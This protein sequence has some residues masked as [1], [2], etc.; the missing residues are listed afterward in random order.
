[1]GEPG[2]LPSMGSHRVGYDW[3]D[4]AVAAARSLSK[5]ETHTMEYYSAIKSIK[6]SAATW[7]Q[8][9]FIIISEVSQRERQ[10]TNGITYMWNLQE[11][12]KDRETWRAAVHGVAKSRAQ[13]S[14]RTTNM[15]NL[16]IWHK[17]TYLQ[18]WDSWTNRADLWR[19]GGVGGWS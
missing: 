12:V 19:R 4:L 14:Q 15:W 7:M 10:I 3:S 17:W 9:E 16:K 18:D 1:M 5:T 13:L 11:M 6:P 2:G 8:P